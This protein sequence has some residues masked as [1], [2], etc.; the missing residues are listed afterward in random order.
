M[1]TLGEDMDGQRQ[2]ILRAQDD[3]L[4]GAGSEVDGNECVVCPVK[5]HSLWAWER[6]EAMRSL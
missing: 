3:L 6:K 5:N 4:E 1:L 2:E